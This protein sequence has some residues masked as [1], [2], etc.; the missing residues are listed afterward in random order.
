M[1]KITHPIRFSTHFGIDRAILQ[2][3]GAFDPLLNAD[4]PLFINP[5]LLAKSHQPEM[6]SAYK[7]WL[8]YFRKIV[9]LLAASTSK[10]DVPW[11]AAA[12]M[13]RTPEFKGTCL[14]YGSGSIQGRGIGSSV[15]AQI[16]TT[17][18]EIVGLGVDDPE[19]F[20][21]LPLFEEGVGSDLLSDQTTRIIAPY[22]AEFTVRVLRGTGVQ[23]QDFEIS[24]ER[25][26]LP[27]NPFNR[28]GRNPLPI[29]LTPKDVLAEL[30]IA[31]GPEDIDSVVSH[32]RALRDR[33]N[34][35]IGRHWTK[36][37]LRRA[38]LSRKDVFED[39]LRRNKQS[40]PY[41]LD[42]DARG[43][44]QWLEVGQRLAQRE[45][46]ALR[47]TANDRSGLWNVVDSIIEHFKQLIED[48]GVWKNLY[49]P[50]RAALPESYV[51]KLFFVLADAYCKANKIDITPE[52]NSGAGPVDFKFSAGYD[53]RLVVEI[54]LSTN[55]RLA[56]GYTQQLQKYKNAESGAEGGFLVID[57]G[58]TGRQLKKVL[59]LETAAVE[60]RR[61]HSKIYVVDG[62][63]QLSASRQ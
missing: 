43:H 53:E 13:L 27:A 49:G 38:I 26:R 30:P 60:S 51:Q 59:A 54:K 56:H 35:R 42:D 61:P 47:L 16:I 7:S 5:L 41:N 34:Q 6:Q 28:D 36:A 10:D 24:A 9:K 58:G 52:A 50:N 3:L 21:L 12:R 46:L 39:F 33:V 32:N 62:Q 44:V 18:K 17:G 63:R 48:K 19:F 25:F 29:V 31:H 4:T 1:G 2:K 37:E 45:P 22:L 8:G 14:G 15:A 23:T 11:R 40:E 20:A 57:L 55:T